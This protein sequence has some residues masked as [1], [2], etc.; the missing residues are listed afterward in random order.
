MWLSSVCLLLAL[1]VFSGGPEWGVG[2]VVRGVGSQLLSGRRKAARPRADGR[3]GQH[4]SAVL[5]LLSVS[6]VSLLFFV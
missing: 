1:E 4:L 3:S 5:F 2:A 6:F